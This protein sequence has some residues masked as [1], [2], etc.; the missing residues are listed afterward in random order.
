MRY[1]FSATV[2]VLSLIVAAISFGSPND[3]YDFVDSVSKVVPLSFLGN[4][5][6]ILRSG[7]HE[8]LDVGLD[9][10]RVLGSPAP[11][12]RG[13]AGRAKWGLREAMFPRTEYRLTWERPTRELRERQACRV[14]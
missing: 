2:V 3:L 11:R 5:K 9:L 7:W 4:V 8:R 14:E 10:G 13:P 12:S 6:F 1:Y